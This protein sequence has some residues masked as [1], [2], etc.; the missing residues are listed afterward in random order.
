LARSHYMRI[1]WAVR[2]IQRLSLFKPN[3]LL[4]ADCR[5]QKR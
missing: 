2:I 3:Q 5:A 4:P 1:N